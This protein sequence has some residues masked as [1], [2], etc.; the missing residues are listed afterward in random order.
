MKNVKFSTSINASAKKVWQVLWSDSTYRQWTGPFQ[1][2]SYAV[3]D[4]K[5]GSK[6]QFLSPKGDGLFSVIEESRPFERMVFKHLGEVK[7]FQEQPETKES[8]EWIGSKEIYILKESNGITTLDVS[9]DSSNEF[10]EYFE[11][12][13][14]K[15]L[16]IVKQLAE[17]PVILTIE[18]EVTAPIDKIWE[19]WT[20]PT[21]IVKWN[22]ASDDWHTTLATNDLKVGGKF[23]SRMEAKDGSFGFDFEGEYTAVEPKKKI[24]YKLADGRKVDVDFIKQNNGYKIVSSFE[25]EEENTLD[26]QQG[27]WQAILNSFK[28]NVENN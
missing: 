14:P 4:W 21:H 22:N 12:V 10:T 28:K 17:K 18:A 5:E 3:S 26:L 2:G 19:H 8:A 7:N 1:E 25:A 27:G 9:L 6:I 23:L 15:A 11:K 24:E 16:E 13:F 20:E